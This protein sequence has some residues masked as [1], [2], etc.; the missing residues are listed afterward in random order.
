MKTSN[1]D[2][3]TT[4]AR[5]YRPD[6]YWRRQLFSVR[7]YSVDGTWTNVYEAVVELH[8]QGKTEVL[9]KTLSQC[10]I[11]HHKSHIKLPASAPGPPRWRRAAMALPQSRNTSRGRH[12]AAVLQ[13]TL[14]NAWQRYIK[15]FPCNADRRTI[16]ANT[17]R[18]ATVRWNRSLETWRL[19]SERTCNTNR[20][21]AES[22]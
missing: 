3:S 6:I 16:T 17:V 8:W 14:R 2:L 22:I 21:N 10:P 15:K 9:G 5:L 18:T 12:N 7:L 13:V 4:D 1:F 20:S 11:V 19:R